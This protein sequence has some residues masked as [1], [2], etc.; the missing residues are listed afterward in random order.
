MSLS[1]NIMASV[2]SL[3]KSLIT[4]DININIKFKQ[5][6]LSAVILCDWISEQ[7]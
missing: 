5:D 6:S 3:L 2:V 1:Q 7:D 4:N